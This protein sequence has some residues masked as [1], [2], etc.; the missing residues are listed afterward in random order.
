MSDEKRQRVDSPGQNLSDEM[1][2]NSTT[3]AVPSDAA[4]ISTRPL[5][6]SMRGWKER[7]NEN[8]GWEKY[9]ETQGICADREELDQMKQAFQ[10]P[11]PVAI[12]VNL[13]AAVHTSALM[14]CADLAELD[15][16]RPNKC[17]RLSWSTDGNAWQW[18]DVSRTHVRKDPGL[19]QL[20]KWFVDH[21]N[22]GT[23]TRQ[24]AVSMIP[25]IVLDPQPGD[26]VLDMCAAPGS[27]T[28]QMIEALQTEGVVVASDVEWKRANMLSHQVQ[29]LSSPANIV[30]NQDATMFP[31]IAG[32]DRVLCDVPCTGDGTIRKSPDIWRRWQISD[33]NGLHV[34]QLQ[35]LIRGLNLVKPG[36]TLVYSTCSLNPIENEAVVAAA[37]AQFKDTVELAPMPDL[38]GLLYRPGMGSW[39]VFNDRT[40]EEVKS[41]EEVKTL[42]SEGKAGKLRVSMFPPP[43]ESVVAQLS[44]T[45]RFLPHL[46]NTGG[47]YVAKFVKKST[48]EPIRNAKG[49]GQ[50]HSEIIPFTEDLYENIVSFYGLDRERVPITQLF[51]RDPQKKHI[52][53]VSKTAGEI[54]RQVPSSFKLVSMGVRAF[55]EV[56]NWE[57]PCRYR[58]TQE[59]VESLR[60]FI[61]LR[62]A[63][64]SDEMFVTFLRDRIVKTEE[65]P[66]FVGLEKGGGIVRM[67]SNPA[68]VVAVMTSPQSVFVYADKLVMDYLLN[69]LSGIHDPTSVV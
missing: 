44:R 16:S 10:T 6:D 45:A 18:N 41:V 15:A 11:L 46:M 35:I 34:R 67:A 24:E 47:F 2:A 13:S 49:D 55:A 61:S 7:V 26:V 29:R 9:Y 43:D 42:E 62:T 40:K 66:E 14:F 56:G 52:Y 27:K 25:P 39:K 28:C 65:I 36:G 64:V 4:T 37:L 51:F 60:S 53:F 50:P 48:A 59:G 63:T 23:L 19:M 21:E 32:F 5:T 58:I 68:V 31:T 30:C 1:P 22:I 20:K 33:G 3:E 38:P 69:I 57:S 17:S 54:L 12:R 8:A